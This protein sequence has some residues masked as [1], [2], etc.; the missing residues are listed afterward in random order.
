MGYYVDICCMSQAALS[1][2]NI[3]AFKKGVRLYD[4]RES[5]E[6]IPFEMKLLYNQQDTMLEMNATVNAHAVM[7][8]LGQFVN[9]NFQ[10]GE[11]GELAEVYHFIMDALK[12]KSFLPAPIQF[13]NSI[14]SY[15]VE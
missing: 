13:I 6:I 2:K 10:D 8:L 4:S 5:K 9:S 3:F 1:K 11:L 14:C 15:F 7:R 12:I